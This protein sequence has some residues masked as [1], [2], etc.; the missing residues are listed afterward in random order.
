M[1]GIGGEKI[2]PPTHTIKHFAF[3]VSVGEIGISNTLA[4]TNSIKFKIVK[5]TPSGSA[6]ADSL[7]GIKHFCIF[8]SE[9]EIG[10]SS[11]LAGTNSIKYKI[12]KWTPS[13]AA[14]ADSLR[15]IC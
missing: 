14:F 7:R 4:R 10:I 1:K 12:L 6:F 5:W 9:G 11:T 15:G 3:F 13:G 2:S 8:V